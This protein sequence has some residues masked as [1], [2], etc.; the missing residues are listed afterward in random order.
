LEDSAFKDY[1]NYFQ[2]LLGFGLLL[3][4]IEFFFPERKLS[5]T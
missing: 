5:T 1:R 4:I 2:W 3:V